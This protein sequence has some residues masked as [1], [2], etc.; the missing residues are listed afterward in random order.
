VAGAVAVVIFGVFAASFRD[1]TARAASGAAD[2]FVCNA[3]RAWRAAHG[4]SD[5]LRVIGVEV[6]FHA[7]P[8]SFAVG[9]AEVLTPVG[10]EL[11][12]A[13]EILDVR[14]DPA[15]SRVLHVDGTTV[16]AWDYPGA[17]HRD[18]HF[19]AATLVR[20]A[21]LAHPSI[22][23]HP[24]FDTLS[25]KVRD[26]ALLKA[27]SLGEHRL[28]RCKAFA[29]WVTDVAGPPPY[30]EQLLRIARRVRAGAGTND[31]KK[32]H[33]DDVCA[34]VRAGEFSEHYAQVV[35]VMALR[36]LGAPA[37]GLES[38]ASPHSLVTTYVDGPG[39]VTLDVLNPDG[40]FSAGGVGFVAKVPLVGAFEG[41]RDGFWYPTAA[42]YR[43]SQG[44][45]RGISWTTWN[46]PD[47]AR[48][49]DSTVTFDRPLAEVCP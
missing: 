43:P 15:P 6:V 40:G 24:T 20:R 4:T 23:S 7:A 29:P 49:E 28:N 31:P 1:G 26:D 22:P 33:V 27:Q 37:Y 47:K 48:T 14:A 32:K 34:A 25:E 41:A 3:A 30:T 46:D 16:L 36:E 8:D 45:P 9:Q 38:A 12:G 11:S 39:W 44:E 21:P 10:S 18:M 13:E 5:D 2:P 42:A 17:V 19:I 35:T